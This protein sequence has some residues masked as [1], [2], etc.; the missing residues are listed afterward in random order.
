MSI[1]LVLGIAECLST[2]TCT[3]TKA[4]SRGAVELAVMTMRAALLPGGEAKGES[5]SR[6][7]IVRY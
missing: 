1:S 3:Y 4:K 7:A 6:F 2:S 5:S